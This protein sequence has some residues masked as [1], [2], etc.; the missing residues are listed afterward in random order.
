MDNM[1]PY[2]QNEHGEL[3]M[4]DCLEIM[5]NVDDGIIDMILC[6]LPYG[7]TARNKWDTV[8]S[9]EP[10]WNH[11]KRVIKP[12]GAIILTAA[13]PFSS[14]LVTSNPKMFRYDL[15]WEK[16][17]GTGF[18]NANRMPLR[19]HEQILVFYKKLPTYNPQKTPGSPYTTVRKQI[20]TNYGMARE[21]QH[22]TINKDGMRYPL[23]VM[24]YSIDKERF[25]PTQ[26]PLLLFMNLIKTYSN[27]GDLV[28][29][30]CI[31]SGTTAVACQKLNRRFIGIELTQEYC[32]ISVGRIEKGYV[33]KK[34]KKQKIVLQQ[35]SLSEYKSLPKRE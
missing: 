32:D 15:I 33:P 20:G 31:G 23:S 30:N 1:K 19:N 29:D 14:L 27:E 5:R 18:L 25:H 26:K 3:Y 22:K 9:F 6:D 21:E 4:G 10:L 16:S 8:I 2:F 13:E 24:K 35:G 34:P 7:I 17:R 11:Y 28:L 12:T